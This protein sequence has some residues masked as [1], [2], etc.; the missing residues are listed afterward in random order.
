MQ[1]RYLTIYLGLVLCAGVGTLHAQS[2]SRMPPPMPSDNTL[3]A[4]ADVKAISAPSD[5]SISYSEGPRH[6]DR[7]GRRVWIAVDA[8]GAVEYFIGDTAGRKGTHTTLP[9]Q[10][11]RIASVAV[12]RMYARAL[13]CG[14]FDLKPYYANPRVRDGGYRR[15]AVTADGKT[16]SVVVSYSRV[17]RFSSIVETLRR[18][19][20]LPS[21]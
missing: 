15:L 9:S 18:E 5:F 10:R 11:R 3:C 8:N 17:R 4:D 12:G 6:A 21:Y 14:F 1:F 7:P 20:G 16:H 19:A 2:R 13:S